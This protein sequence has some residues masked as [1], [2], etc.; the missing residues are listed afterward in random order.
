[1]QSKGSFMAG[2]IVNRRRESILFVFGLSARLGF[3]VFGQPTSISCKKV[4][5]EKIY[6]TTIFLEVD[7]RVL[8]HFNCKT[9]E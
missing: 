6:Q 3:K 9:L 2:S 7:D 4:Q 1:M 5:E 8:V